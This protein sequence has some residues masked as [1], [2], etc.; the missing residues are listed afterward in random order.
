MKTIPRTYRFELKSIQGQKVLLNKPFGCVQYIYNHFLNDRKEQY[1]ADKKSD[2]YYAQAKT[3]I[4]LKKQDGT[5]WLKEVNSQTLQFTLRSLDTAHLNFFRG[6]AKFPSF[7][8]N[9]N[10]NSFTVAQHTKL[11]D[12]KEVKDGI[13]CI[14]HR[15]VKGEVGKMTFSKTPTGRYFVSILTEEQYQPKERAGAVCGV[16]LG[17][18]DFAIISN[19]TKFKNNQYTKKYEKFSEGTKTSFS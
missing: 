18:K 10:K 5:I 13:K 14:V 9:K 6:N 16:Y 7:K 3:L 2:N 15:D 12:G 19:G 17:L 11:I 4:E 1:E 8:S